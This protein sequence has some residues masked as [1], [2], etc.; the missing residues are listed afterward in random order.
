MLI[1][2][3][4][5]AYATER[6]SEYIDAINEYG[7]FRSAARALNINHSPL[8]EAIKLLRRRAATSGYAP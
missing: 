7:G 3:G 5:K 6:Q 2:E 1:D 4:L 8:V